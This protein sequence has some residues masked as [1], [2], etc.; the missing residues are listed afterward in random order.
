VRYIEQQERS[1]PL[2]E[3]TWEFGSLAEI[4]V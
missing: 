4:H 3:E 2:S 1:Y